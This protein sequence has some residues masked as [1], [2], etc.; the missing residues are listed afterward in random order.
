M[1]EERPVKTQEWF[2]QGTERETVQSGDAADRPRIVYPAPDTLIALDPDI[3][4]EVQSVFF[5]SSSPAKWIL[6]G[7]EVGTFS[8]REWKPVPGRHELLL[9]APSGVR[10]DR[11]SFEVR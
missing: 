6:D 11:I 10:V 5:E 7:K 9:E 3:P 2:I 8:L 4:L 1:N